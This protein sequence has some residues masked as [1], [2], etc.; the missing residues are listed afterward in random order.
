MADF[1]FLSYHSS[2]LELTAHLARYF[3]KNNFE[4]WYAPRNIHSGEQWDE[5]INLAIR[6]C[7][8]VV[9]LFCSQAD[10][11]LQVKRELSLAD[12]YKKPVFWVRVERVEPNNLSYFLTSTQWFDWLDERDDTLSVLVK[13][14]RALDQQP[15]PT[16][17]SASHPA[18]AVPVNNWAKGVLA[19]GSERESAECAARVYFKLAKNHPDSSMI[20]PTGRSATSLFRAMLRLARKMEGC[21]FGEAHLITDTET[22]GVW[23]EHETSRTRHVN[24]MLIEPLK[25]MGKAPEPDQL[26]LLSGIFMQ[27]DPVKDAQR[28]LRFYPP[29]VHAVSVSPFGEI[30]AYEVGTY[31]D[32]DEIVDDPP[33]ILEVGKHSKKYIDPDQP[34]QSILSIGLGT[35]L[36]TEILLIL[37]FD[38][39]KA[40]ILNRMFTGPAVAGIPA[41][42]LRLH[43]NAYVLTTDKIAQEADITDLLTRNMTPEEAAEWII[44]N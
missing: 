1:I 19:F 24:E 3:E 36:S 6:E 37:F 30:L 33:R 38:I 29:V 12:R 25:E 16:E 41:T 28:V 26:H 35:A 40:G 2:K 39:Q 21:P 44:E 10:S 14:I 42:L 18:R 7:R 34:S 13:D 4:T 15:A 17:T 27:D 31:T 43:P 8:A 20:L 5:A 32:P 22:F 9:L 23:R 11:S